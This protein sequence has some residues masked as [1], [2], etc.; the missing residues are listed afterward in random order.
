[1]K[2]TKLEHACL[3][4]EK[5]G[6]KLVVDPG[7]FT[8]PL[9]DP[10]DVTAIVITH[11]HPDHWTP[12]HLTRIL[13]ASPDAVV[14]GPAGVAAAASDFPVVT[15]AD[16][17][18]ITAGPF[19]LTFFGAQHA[20]IHSS[21]PVI[22]NVGVMIDGAV[23]YPGDSFTVPPVPVSTLVVP[24]GA[25]W[26]KIGEVMD[27]VVAVKPERTIPT[28]QMVL[29]VIGQQMSNGRIAGAGASVGAEALVLE[30]GESIDL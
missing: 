1:M 7:S 4:L 22:D 11:E 13:E 28:H 12:E 16:G 18:A 10:T 26:L 15:V 25:P 2:L 8:I 30:P 17:D 5:N 9:T 27:Y 14:Y 3:V 23:F 20:V 21:I 29:S 6:S 19:E 24:A